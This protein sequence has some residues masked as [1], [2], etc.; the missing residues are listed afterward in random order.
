MR[1][2]PRQDELSSASASARY[3]ACVGQLMYLA[4]DRLDLQYAA[5]QLARH[6]ADPSADDEAHLRR[7]VRYVRDRP[8]ASLRLG[9]QELPTH[10]TVMVDADWAGD[11]QTRRSVSGGLLI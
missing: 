10:L 3:R 9:A 11:P 5:G 6:M 4:L 2:V 1:A 7:A 8:T